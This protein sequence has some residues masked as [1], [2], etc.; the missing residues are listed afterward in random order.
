MLAF[1][2]RGRFSSPGAA[3]VIKLNKLKAEVD[4]KLAKSQ[5]DLAKS[6]ETAAAN[7]RKT[8]EAVKQQQKAAKLA[9]ATVSEKEKL[10]ARLAASTGENTKLQEKID[11][12]LDQTKMTANMASDGAKS[13]TAKEQAEVHPNPQTPPPPHTHTD[14]H[15]PP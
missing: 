9:E 8:K 4:K 14:T 7:E 12:L 11:A 15:T 6:R 2:C 3:T 13:L 10:V 1:R 5:A